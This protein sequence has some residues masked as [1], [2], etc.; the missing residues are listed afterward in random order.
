MAKSGNQISNMIT[1]QR[2]KEGFEDIRYTLF[3]TLKIGVG[4][5]TLNFF[6]QVVGV[7][8]PA[9]TNMK[10]SGMLPA[11][12]SFLVTEMAIKIFNRNGA[13]LFGNPAAVDVPYPINVIAALGSWK[14]KYEPNTAYEGHLLEFFEFVNI[15]KD[16]AAAALAVA[17]LPEG[18]VTKIVRFG[19]LPQIIDSG[20]NFGVEVALTAPAAA[21]GGFD[22]VVASGTVMQVQLMGVLRR[23]S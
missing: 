14:F 18:D 6:Q 13:A 11:G 3:D 20:R 5:N 2:R 1:S 7:V 12:T 19:K 4:I 15:Q 17:G 22:T 21:G 16:G 9:N 23:K 10:S 8:G